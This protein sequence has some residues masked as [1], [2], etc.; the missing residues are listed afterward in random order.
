MLASAGAPSLD[1]EEDVEIATYLAGEAI[2]RVR[3]HGR[4]DGPLV[5]AAGG[6]SADRH[7]RAWWGG[8]AAPGAGLDLNQYCVLGFDFAPLADRRAPITPHVQAQL[9]LEAL[10][11]LGVAQAHGFV[12]ASYGAM[13]GLALAE[14][15]PA[16]VGRLVV[17]SAAHRPSA[18]ASGWR[19]VQRRIVEQALAAGDGAAGLALARQLAMITYRSAE[20]FE[21]RFDRAIGDDGRSD[22]DHYL[23]ARGQAY[24]NAVAARRWLC[25][26]EAIDRFAVIPEKI[27]APTTLVACPTDQ[28]APLKDMEEFATRLP[29]C[30]ALKLLPSLY[31]HDAFLKETA[32]LEPI[33]R[34][35]LDG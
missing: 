22:L 27:A 6:I 32:R 35:A 9:L 13:V 1:A 2:V 11:K 25:L 15:A 4:R 30:A 18:L 5:I 24:A 14:L 12:G 34:E 16:R 29:R 3:L 23:V 7:V 17:I 10:D 21:T 8:L 20:E 28:L 26:S 31:G 19:G 33:I